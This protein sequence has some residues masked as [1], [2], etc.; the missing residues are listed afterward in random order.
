VGFGATTITVTATLND[1][2]AYQQ[3]TATNFTL[4]GTSVLNVTDPT[5]DDNGPGTFQ[6]PTDPSFLPGAFDLTGMKVNQDDTNVYV[7]V[8]I[9]NLAPTFGSDFGAQLMDLYVHAPA[10]SPTS[11]GATFESRNYT[12]APADAWSQSIEAQGFSNP[13]WLNAS[14]TSLGT[15]QFVV[16]DTGNT[17]TLVFPKATFGTVGSGWTFTVAL[18]GQ[19]GFG[20]DN[21]RAFT[22]NPGAFSFGEC[23]VGGSSP[24]CSVPVGQLPEVM[25]TIP[26]AGVDQSAELDP[27]TGPVV[28]Q[29]VTVP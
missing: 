8:Q 23:A 3:V 4:P 18:F 9:R 17:A 7:Q 14:G 6:Y 26:P 13:T 29:G 5:G 20:N 2:T 22:T 24:I 27:T 10:A 15:P 11:T 12:I 28:L 16:D 1:A 19:D 25:D 21:A